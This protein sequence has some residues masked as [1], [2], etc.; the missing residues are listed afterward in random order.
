M[1]VHDFNLNDTVYLLHSDIPAF[2]SDFDETRVRI[3]FQNGDKIVREWF[4]HTLIQREPYRNVEFKV[5][6]FGE[7][8]VGEEQPTLRDWYL[9]HAMDKISAFFDYE[10]LAQKAVKLADCMMRARNRTEPEMRFFQTKVI[11]DVLGYYKYH[12]EANGMVLEI[13][14]EGGID[15]YT[16]RPVL[17]DTCDVFTKVNPNIATFAGAEE[18]ELE[19]LPQMLQII[20][21]R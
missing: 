13:Y 16:I 17:S 19:D 2:V 18:C 14:G 15:N 4:D 9:M 12:I 3:T 5:V 8:Q 20:L 1:R 7:L 11:G 10:Q 6:P 21:K